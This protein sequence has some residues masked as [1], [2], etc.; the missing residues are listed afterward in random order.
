MDRSPRVKDGDRRDPVTGNFGGCTSKAF[1][2]VDAGRREEEERV[3]ELRRASDR[4]CALILFS[5]LP[6]I[7]VRIAAA[8]ARRLCGRLFPGREALYDRIYLPR[9]RRLWEQW[10]TGEPWEGH[11][12]GA[13]RS[14]SH[15]ITDSA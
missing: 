13:S 6:L 4:V 15:S 9:F 11:G 3:E 12:P 14:G 1:P 5:D 8:N 7:D 2:A 10:R